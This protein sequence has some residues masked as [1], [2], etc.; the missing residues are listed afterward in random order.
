M[1]YVDLENWNR[2]DHYY[3]FRGI[4]YPQFNLCANVDITKFYKFVKE[5]GYHFSVSFIYAASKTANSIKEFRYRIR[6]DKVVEHEVIHPSFTIMGNNDVFSF[7][8]VVYNDD[9]KKFSADASKQIEI[10]KNNVYIKDEPGA[11][12][13]LYMTCIPWVSFTGACHPIHMH[14]VDSIPRVSWGKYFEDNGKIKMPISVQVHHA[15]M[16]GLHVGRYFEMIQD[17][18][19][20]PEKY[21]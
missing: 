10:T 14:P 20:T 11:D 1:K 2:K 16:D 12:N 8:K 21:Y 18:L 13:L 5:N 3:Y 19:D 7:C 4:D 15:M 17:I 6:E 9:F